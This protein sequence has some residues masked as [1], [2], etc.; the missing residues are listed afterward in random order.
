MPDAITRRA[1]ISTRDSIFTPPLRSKCF[2][3]PRRHNQQSAELDSSIRLQ[4]VAVYPGG[5]VDLNCFQPAIGQW[6]TVIWARNGP[7]N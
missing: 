5:S 1:I 3:F 7:S 2:D 4:A 6:L